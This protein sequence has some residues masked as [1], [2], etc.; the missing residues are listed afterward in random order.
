MTATNS[1]GTTLPW[2]RSGPPKIPGLLRTVSFYRYMQRALPKRYGKVTI[3]Q[4]VDMML[5]P[6]TIGT[7]PRSDP[8]PPTMNPWTCL[9][10]LSPA[11]ARAAHT[12]RSIV[13]IAPGLPRRTRRSRAITVGSS[14]K[15]RASC[16]GGPTRTTRTRLCA[17]RV[18][19]PNALFGSSACRRI[20]ARP[21]LAWPA[22]GTRSC[23]CH[24][25]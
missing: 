2:K 12:C 9:T 19:R 16:A 18:I 5:S 15:P 3:V 8:L 11:G 13:R 23:R 14:A 25:S 10:Q 21:T 1:A 7:A 24:G 4:F 20:L 22:T 6:G 17:A